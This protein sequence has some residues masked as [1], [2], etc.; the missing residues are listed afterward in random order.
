MKKLIY[1]ARDDI[2]SGKNLDVWI[3]VVLAFIFALLG[4]LGADDKLLNACVLGLL[5]ILAISQ[6]KSRH[7]V[8]EVTATWQR[9]RTD[10]FSADFPQEYYDARSQASSNYFFSGTTMARTLPTMQQDI[11]RIL[12]NGGSVRI[13][14]PDPD[15]EHLIQMI[16]KSRGDAVEGIRRS[17]Q[18]ALATATGIRSREGHNFEIRTSH[19]LPRVG[20]NA[21]EL[22]HPSASIMIQMYGIAPSSESKPIFLLTP[23]DKVWFNHFQDEIERL[24]SAGVDHD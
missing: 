12:R 8:A 15:N 1:W 17:I 11:T 21:M 24:W 7:Q 3:L 16:A 22:G 10:I 2:K 5:G 4:I 20:I 13:L 6:I 9:A 18:H 14:L 19:V 23:D